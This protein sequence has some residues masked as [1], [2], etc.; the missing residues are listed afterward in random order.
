MAKVKKLRKKIKEKKAVKRGERRLRGKHVEYS[1]KKEWL[2]YTRNQKE[3]IKRLMEGNYEMVTGKGWGFLDDFF[4]F[5][6]H[7]GFLS[8]LNIEGVGFKRKVIAITKLLMT[9]STKILLG[10][11]S[12]NQV[13]EKLFGDIGLLKLL[14][15]SVRQVKEGFTNRGKYEEG[16]MHKNTLADATG[17]VTAEESAE[18]LN[19]TARIIAKKNMVP[20][21]GKYALDAT[22]LETTEKYRGCGRKTINHRKRDKNGKIVE[23][24][25]TTYGFKL[26]AVYEVNTRIIVAAKIVKIQESESNYTIEMLKMAQANLGE[27]KIKT[28]LIDRGFIDGQD[29]WKIK[30]EY[31]VDFVIP[32]KTDMEITKDIRMLRD[33]KDKSIARE[34]RDVEKEGRTSL[35]GVD[36]FKSYIQ[37]SKE[38]IK[39]GDKNKNGDPIN[40]IM[41]YEYKGKLYEPGEEKVFLTSLSAK[42]PLKVLDEYDLRSLIENCC[43]RELKQGWNLLSYPKKT[44]QAV[45][46]HVMLTLC[47]FSLCNAYRTKEGQKLKDAGIRRFRRTSSSDDIHKIVIYAG[48][49][50]GIFDVE[51]LMII[52]GKTPE[53]LFRTDE[54]EVKKKYGIDTSE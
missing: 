42:K 49:Y 39:E 38:L 19:K 35:I 23:I 33:E 15:F 26:L 24:P 4:T 21:E 44:R 16:P 45:E 12:M 53:Y 6:W 43:F 36:G 9:Y 37:Y 32:A 5:L 1:R 47:I 25:E 48:G 41:V 20:K 17:R 28:L 11:S 40:A 2:L 34:S 51:E 50:Y 10:I 29:L 14:G 8:V 54:V 7:I 22:D 27:K 18:I 46:C 52:F 3:V 13:T 31:G 30:N